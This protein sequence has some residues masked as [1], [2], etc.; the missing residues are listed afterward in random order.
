MVSE[1]D[2]AIVASELGVDIPRDRREWDRFVKSHMD[3]YLHKRPKQFCE[4]AAED[5]VIVLGYARELWSPHKELPVT[6]I[7]AATKVFKSIILLTTTFHT[8]PRSTTPNT[9]AVRP[10]LTRCFAVCTRSRT[11]SR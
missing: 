11:A 3:I 7:S 10:A 6:L 9:A 2:V 4:Y 5:A 8:R 1:D